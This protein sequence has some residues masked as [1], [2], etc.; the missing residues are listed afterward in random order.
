MKHLSFFYIND[1]CRIS[2]NELYLSNKVQSSSRI[3]FVEDDDTLIANEEGVV[4]RLN[5]FFSNAVINLKDPKFEN[6]EPFSENIDHPL[7]AIVK[8]RKNP[9][10]I[11]IV[12]KFTKERI[13]FNAI[14]IEDA[15]K[16]ISM[17]NIYAG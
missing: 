8:Y 9:S 6:S 3:K 7:K 10:F 12:S 2:L 17:F 1:L 11:A 5:N 14:T 15:L 4:I 13:S 16:E